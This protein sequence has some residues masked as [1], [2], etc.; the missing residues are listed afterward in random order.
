VGCHQTSIAQQ[1]PW[2]LRAHA[3]EASCSVSNSAL[4]TW[5]MHTCLHQGDTD[6][7]CTEMRIHVTALGMPAWPHS[8]CRGQ[9]D[10]GP[11]CAD[12]HV[13]L[14][15]AQAAGGADQ[16]GGG[17]RGG[18]PPACCQHSAR[19][20]NPLCR[21]RARRHPAGAVQ[22]WKGAGGGVPGAHG[23]AWSTHASEC[24]LTH[25]S[26]TLWLSWWHASWQDADP[27]SAHTSTQHMHP[28]LACSRCGGGGCY[29]GL[30]L[31][32]LLLLLLLNAAGVPEAGGQHRRRAGSCDR[33]IHDPVEV[34]PRPAEWRATMLCRKS[35]P[36]KLFRY[37]SSAIPCT[38]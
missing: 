33:T 7:D 14:P 23:H 20:G 16:G 5:L 3:Q 25:T 27:C 8:A 15:R 11:R 10:R 21:A 4:C 38:V 28:S 6:D 22:R 12:P 9:L 37:S 34:A 26:C 13:G 17:A 18:S 35:A 2:N 30:T 19:G 24:N 36:A 29:Q 32:L 31:P 1:K